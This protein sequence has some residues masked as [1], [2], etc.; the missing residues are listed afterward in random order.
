MFA[1]AERVDHGH[2]GPLGEL[3]DRVVRVGSGG[4]AVH[5]PPEHP[6]DVAYRLPLAGADL[7]RSEVDRAPAEALHRD[8]EGDARAQRGLLEDERQRAPGEQRPAAIALDRERRVEQ[9]AELPRGE[10]E[11]RRKVAGSHR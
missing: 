2:S 11:D 1:L 6:R 10:I 3:K 5:H 7:L 9:I 8:L 4:D